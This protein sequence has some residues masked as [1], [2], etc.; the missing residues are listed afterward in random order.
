MHFSVRETAAVISIGL[1]IF[2]CSCEKHP[3]GEDPEVQKEHVDEAKGSS[4]E[5]NAS[6]PNKVEATENATPNRTPA[7][8]FPKTTPSP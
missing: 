2:C 6:V 3:L 4:D 8:F 5:E 1:L 7:E